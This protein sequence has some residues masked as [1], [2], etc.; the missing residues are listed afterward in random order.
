V[1]V[2]KWWS[3]EKRSGGLC[4]SSHLPPLLFCQLPAPSQ[5]YNT[6]GVG[7]VVQTEQGSPSGLLSKKGPAVNFYDFQPNSV[8]RILIFISKFPTDHGCFG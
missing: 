6:R 5:M 3:I 4:L 2:D 7:F 1:G 8:R